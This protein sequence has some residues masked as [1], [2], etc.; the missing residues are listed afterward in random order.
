MQ[1]HFAK[2][3][4]VAALLSCVATSTLAPAAFA[5]DGAS[6]AQSDAIVVTARKREET[7]QDVPVSLNA[8]GSDQLE[9]ANVRSGKDIAAI[10][11]GLVWKGDK[12]VGGSN[13]FIRGIGTTTTS[14][15]IASAVGVYFDEVYLSSQL[16]S[17]I[18]AYDLARVEVLKGPQGTLY[19]QNTT[20]GAIRFIPKAPRVGGGESADIKVDVGNYG[21]T[22]VEGGASF[23]ISSTM[24]ARVSFKNE[25]RNG[26]YRNLTD[27]G[28]M[29]K[30]D[31]KA[32]RLQ[33]RWEPVD[34]LSIEPTV[35][36]AKA[37]SDG[38]FYKRIDY[39]NET[40]DGYCANP[41][42]GTAPGCASVFGPYGFDVPGQGVVQPDGNAYH[43]STSFGKTAEEVVKMLGGSLKVEYGLGAFSVTS[44]TSYYDV[45]DHVLQDVDDA[46]PNLTNQWDT[47]HTHQFTQE[48]RLT[49][50]TSGP[51]D[52][53]VGA[54]YFDESIKAEV[55]V[56]GPNYAT[57]YDQ[58]SKAVSLFGESTYHFTDK[59]A[60]ALGL[61]WSHDKREIDFATGG[62]SAV[63]GMDYIDINRSDL[64]D[65]LSF[66]G[67]KSWGR[68]SGRAVL[69][70]KLDDALLYA[71]YSRGFKGGVFNLGAASVDAMNFVKPETV[72]AYELGVKSEWFDNRL[73]LN[74]A[75][76]YYDYKDKQETYFN[77]GRTILSNAQ[78]RV[79]GLEIDATAH[80]VRGMTLQAGASLLDTK[81]TSFPGC[82][83]EYGG[84]DLL[85]GAGTTPINCT[86]NRL[87]GAPKSSIYLMARYDLDILGRTLTPQVD[88]RYTSRTFFNYENLDFNSQGGYW[89]VNARLGYEIS[90]AIKLSGWVQNI[91]SK[92]Y[93]VDGYNIS[94][95]GSGLLNPGKPRTY[96][97][98]L[99]MSF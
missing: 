34:N 27:G 48:L 84:P 23:D 19:G 95:T 2:R 30:L 32:L 50:T 77:N 57:F 29:G 4:V 90:D 79:Y 59:L 44:V 55:A 66:A 92:Q 58:K 35:N 67:S 82:N 15:G 74:A 16:M 36:Y 94:A 3:R 54:Y 88:A 37:S 63:N 89:L 25:S 97:A 5:A 13:I 78:A 53:V 83:V 8:F 71:S 81:Y 40:M 21:A 64:V 38:A 87:T 61:R 6:A 33:L 49:S 65:P 39:T 99:E 56:Y 31:S 45:K 70:Y 93:Y 26:I 20:G 43:L 62:A 69:S 96:G 73:I 68:F 76:F 80:P 98:T 9:S 17:N 12:V 91:A 85:V 46:A 18:A 51:L 28:H 86:G 11:P 1:N 42:P 24:A 60:L 72:D 14:A 41:R 10:T 52:W 22:N 47:N 75:A 7:A